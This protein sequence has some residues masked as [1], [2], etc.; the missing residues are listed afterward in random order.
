LHPL[1]EL[2]MRT[3]R[4][5]TDEPRTAAVTLYLSCGFQRVDRLRSWMRRNCQDWPVPGG[6]PRG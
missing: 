2:G 5:A 4:V 6:I 3:A 1:R